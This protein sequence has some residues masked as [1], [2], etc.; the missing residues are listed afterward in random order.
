MP[1]YETE[2][3]SKRVNKFNIAASSFVGK[4]GFVVFPLVMLSLNLMMVQ[5]DG[6]MIQSY[7]LLIHQKNKKKLSLKKLL[8]LKSPQNT[9]SSIK[10]CY[11]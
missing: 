3:K 6:T 7:H 4:D 9:K 1:C 8:L 11:H 5:T 2:S 10:N